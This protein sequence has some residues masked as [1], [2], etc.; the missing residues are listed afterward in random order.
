M[1]RK[2]RFSSNM[3]MPN[4]INNLMQQAKRMQQ[5]IEE[6]QMELSGKEFTASAGGGAVEMTVNGQRQ[7]TKVH[8]K[9]ELVDLQDIEMLEDLIVAASNEALRKVEEEATSSMS[10][11]NGEGE[12]EELGGLNL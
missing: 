12:I 6:K 8:L 4:N 3:R 2:G 10:K 5:Q 7:V 11:L 1:K 9:K